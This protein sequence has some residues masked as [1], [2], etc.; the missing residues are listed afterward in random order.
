MLEINKIYYCCSNCGKQE[1]TSAMVEVACINTNRNF[2]GIELDD[3]YFEIAKR[4]IS[5]AQNKS[6]QIKMW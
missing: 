6:E 1:I 2:I 3:K 5:E 4:R